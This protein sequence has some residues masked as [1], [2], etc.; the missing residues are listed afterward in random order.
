MKA[1][2]ELDALV[3]RA[4]P[5]ISSR[6]YST[7]ISSAW[8]LVEGTG[9]LSIYELHH[10]AESNLW[11]IGFGSDGYRFESEFPECLTAPHA[12][13]LAVLGKEN[14]IVWCCARKEWVLSAKAQD[15]TNSKP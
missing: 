9:L 4:L 10:D 11:Q 8:A 12:L 14:F 15:L 13:C 5:G 7:D 2:P 6:P 1:G 3:I